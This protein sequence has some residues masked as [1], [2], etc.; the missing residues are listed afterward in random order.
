MK[1][2]S[3]AK[4]LYYFNLIILWSLL[5]LVKPVDAYVAGEFEAAYKSRYITNMNEDDHQGYQSLMIYAAPEKNSPFQLFFS[6]DLYEDLNHHDG[7]FDEIASIYNSWDSAIHGTVYQCHGTIKQPV[8]F[9]DKLSLGRQYIHYSLSDH[10]DGISLQKKSYG[11]IQSFQVYCG[12]PVRYFDESSFSNSIHSGIHL[13]LKLP[14]NFL[15]TV[16][17]QLTDDEADALSNNHDPFYQTYFSVAKFFNTSYFLKISSVAINDDHIQHIRVDS[18]CLIDAIALKI[19]GSY[20]YQFVEIKNFPE[21]ISPLLIQWAPIKPHHI[22]QIHFT[23]KEKEDQWILFG[24]ILY[25]SL[26]EGEH[27]TSLNH[28]YFHQYLGFQIFDWPIPHVDLTLQGDIWK[29][30]E[31]NENPFFTTMNCDIEY[32]KQGLY[33]VNLG[34]AYEMYKYDYYE[35]KD[36]KMDVYTSYLKSKICI[37]PTF[38]IQLDYSVDYYDQVDHQVSLRTR[39]Y[40]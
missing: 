29:D 40:F 18:T 16:E 9:L 6:G 25:R 28:S 20:Y 36:E 39:Y 4:S 24:G 32:E 27:E 2:R 33:Q 23:H 3:Y 30:I 34:M 17:H 1:S 5:T 35:D 13:S 19:N 26:T 10:I 15:F 14:Q 22:A 12:S 21:S 31:N 8:A 7:Q 11:L 38:Q 37:T